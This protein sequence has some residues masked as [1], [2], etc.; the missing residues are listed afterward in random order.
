MRRGLALAVLLPTLGCFAYR[1]PAEV[2]DALGRRF[3]AGPEREIGFKGGLLPD[4]SAGGAGRGLS[5]RR[6]P[7]TRRGGRPRPRAWPPARRSRDGASRPRAS[8]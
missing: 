6:D 3:G 7:V 8:S 5:R 4:K 2:R 1:E